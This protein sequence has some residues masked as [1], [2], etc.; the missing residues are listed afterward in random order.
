MA[1]LSIGRTAKS[2]EI[3]S[4]SRIALG[5]QLNSFAQTAPTTFGLEVLAKL[6]Q[7][8]FQ[9]QAP[10]PWPSG[11]TGQA[12]TSGIVTGQVIIPRR[13]GNHGRM[14]DQICQPEN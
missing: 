1:S 10:R 9:G 14:A 3:P 5:S 7:T 11:Q 4:S 6:Y 8:H 13:H 2:E 12:G